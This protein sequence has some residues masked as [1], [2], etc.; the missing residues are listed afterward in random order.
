MLW[1]KLSN[2]SFKL[3]KLICETSKKQL[4]VSLVG[5]CVWVWVCGCVGVCV[6]TRCVCKVLRMC[7][8]KNIQ[9]NSGNITKPNKGRRGWTATA[10][11]ALK[12][13]K[14]ERQFSVGCWH[15]AQV[16]VSVGPNDAQGSWKTWQMTDWQ[17]RSRGRHKYIYIFFTWLKKTS[18]L[19]SSLP[20]WAESSGL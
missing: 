18:D 4:V 19:P 5:V 13:T 3:S 10:A 12:R 6:E 7:K 11:G 16:F 14:R 9:L 2:M 17:G 8:T 20:L 1:A 15:W